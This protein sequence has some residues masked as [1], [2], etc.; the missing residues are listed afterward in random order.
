MTRQT[1]ITNRD[2]SGFT[3]IEILV[4][5]AVAAVFA[6][7][8]SAFFVNG[9]NVFSTQR[10]QSI[11]DIGARRAM[12]TF[13]R[14]VRQA[15][16]PDSGQSAPIVSL[17]ATSVVLY[18]EVSNRVASSATPVLPKPQKV[19]YRLVGTTLV[20]SSAVPIGVPPTL[21]WGPYT[22]VDELAS[23]VQNGSNAVFAAY[24]FRGL[25]L[26]LPITNTK[27]IATIRIR[28]QLGQKTGA[29]KTKTEIATNVSL[30]NFI[31]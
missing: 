5:M 23:D 6:T 27:R 18:S 20:R 14:D 12:Q 7:G 19:E 21:S 26:A 2:E 9:L 4:T 31:L 25:Q 13:V 8:L 3:L 16:T 29:S 30:R 24:D 22:V 11:A 10:S 15:I 1:H 17:D 28:I